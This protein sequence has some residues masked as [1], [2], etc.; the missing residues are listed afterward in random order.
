LQDFG[1]SPLGR[2]QDFG[3]F[4]D[5]NDFEEFERAREN[6]LEDNN[7]QD[8]N[9][10]DNNLP[11]PTE[12]NLHDFEVCNLHAHTPNQIPNQIPNQTP[13]QIPN[14]I[15]TTNGLREIQVSEHCSKEKT[16]DNDHLAPQSPAKPNLAKGRSVTTQKGVKAA[17]K[18]HDGDSSPGHKSANPPPRSGRN[19]SF[20]D[21]I[22]QR[23]AYSKNQT[24]QNQTNKNQTT[25]SRK[26]VK[27]GNREETGRH[28][29]QGLSQS[30]RNTLAARPPNKA[31]QRSLS[32]SRSVTRKPSI[33]PTSFAGRLRGVGSKNGIDNV[34]IP[35]IDAKRLITHGRVHAAGSRS[36]ASTPRFIK[37]Y[38][39]IE[40]CGDNAGNDVNYCNGNPCSCKPACEKETLRRRHAFRNYQAQRYRA[41]YGYHHGHDQC[42]RD[43]VFD[44]AAYL[45][46]AQ[47]ILR[48]L[49][50]DRER[51]AMHEKQDRIQSRTDPEVHP[52]MISSTNVGVQPN[53]ISSS[54]AKLKHS[55]HSQMNQISSKPHDNPFPS[56][57]FGEVDLEA[58]LVDENDSKVDQGSFYSSSYGSHDP[59]SDD[60]PNSVD[61]N[62]GSS[63]GS[64]SSS[65]SSS[66]SRSSSSSANT[67][68][69]AYFGGPLE[70]PRGIMPR[71]QSADDYSDHVLERQLREDEPQVIQNS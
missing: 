64:S 71:K 19:S 59:N 48:G 20:G 16:V 23:E 45:R 3:H 63:S 66:G 11:A 41:D 13:N 29:K 22:A 35:P 65:S 53:M 28:G 33:S 52:N 70:R 21:M 56:S 34:H 4:G 39:D 31:Q 14:Q 9:L 1:Q 42:G 67:C 68:H 12:D 30:R 61:S 2:I 8:N 6:D 40:N 60:D 18:F 47:A 50:S 69:N 15:P 55:Q 32:R 17:V 27:A 44:I 24:N 46:H 43:Q 49:E 38:A 37:D 10:Q 54:A 36:G 62:S 25:K 7:L 26:T 57:V 58:D 51:E 5:R